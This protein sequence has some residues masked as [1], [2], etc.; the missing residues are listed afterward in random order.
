MRRLWWIL[1]LA[2]WLGTSASPASA[3]NCV[4]VNGAT[5]C[6]NTFRFTAPVLVSNIIARTDAVYTLG[7]TTHNFK[8]GFIGGALNLATTSTDG[9]VLQNTTAATAGVTAQYS[10]RVKWCG[11]AW[12]STASSSEVDC[13]AIEVRPVTNAGATTMALT[14]LSSVAGA[15]TFTNLGNLNSAG[16]FSQQQFS[17]ANSTYYEWSGRS[18]LSAPADGLVNVANNQ[19]SF[20]PQ[21]NT[22]TA[23]PTVTTCGTGA[24]TAHSNNT[25]G[26]ITATGASACTVTFGAPNFTNTPQCVITPHKVPTTVPYITAESVSAFT[27]SGMTAGDNL[28]VGFVCIGGI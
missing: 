28:I 1:L 21:I 20:G 8:Q 24:V 14:F 16:T 11:P 2:G 13:F 10:P 22:G 25:A 12:N 19:Q 26:E 23:A 5:T 15:T 3:Q 18:R 17:A 4:V 7:D 27:I 6:A 9:L